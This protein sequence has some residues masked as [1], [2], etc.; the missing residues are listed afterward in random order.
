MAQWAE[1]S[2]QTLEDTGSNPPISIFYNNI[3][4]KDDSKEKDAGNG[5]FEA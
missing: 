3:C 4:G 5:T 2:L 1:P